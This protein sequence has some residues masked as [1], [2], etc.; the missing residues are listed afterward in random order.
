MLAKNGP[1]SKAMND[2][3]KM[4]ICE[5]FEKK[6]EGTL[7]QKE[8]DQLEKITLHDKE[9]SQFYFDLCVQNIALEEHK[10][11]L[12][13]TANFK[14]ETNIRK[15]N[16]FITPFALAAS[17]LIASYSLFFNPNLDP[18]QE[19]AV[20]TQVNSCVW[21][22]S[23]L[24][25]YQ[26]S[27]LEAGIMKLEEGIAEIKFN[28][29]V[30]FQ[31]EGPAHFELITDMHCIVHN[32][33]VVADVPE[34]AKGFRIDTPTA[35]V[36]DHGTRFIVSHQANQKNASSVVEVLE[37]EVEVQGKEMMKSQH[38][39]KGDRVLATRNEIEK[40]SQSEVINHSL[41]RLNKTDSKS[42]QIS[43]SEGLGQEATVVMTNDKSFHYI[44]TIVHL[45]H[46]DSKLIRKGYLRF[47]S[48]SLPSKELASVALSLNMVKTG[49]GTALD[50]NES[51]FSVYGII[52]KLDEWDADK[53]K[54]QDAP[55]NVDEGNEVDPKSTIH[56]GD[57]VLTRGKHDGLVSIET[58]SLLKF[59]Q[60]DNNQLISFVIVRNNIGI[61]NIN[62]I[63]H[64][65]ANSMHPSASAPKLT[66]KFK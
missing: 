63:V 61:G 51:S 27:E 40:N 64:G 31:I 50:M 6:L 10:A 8:A 59:I 21:S 37:G 22:E 1:L 11:E 49:L 65:F 9:A 41:S 47:D 34:Q 7:T 5:F 24:P 60:E 17:L 15:K 33:T 53:I 29:G 12:T 4:M 3:D 18:A 13:R 42:F 62:S 32:G 56:V 48:S 66:F 44:P 14:P 28:S 25:T 36:I 30:K 26:G 19:I 2:K 54:Y 20:L 52:N 58:E 46:S 16:N 57:F 43:S 55:G 38:F 39:F 45:K 23:S 35:K